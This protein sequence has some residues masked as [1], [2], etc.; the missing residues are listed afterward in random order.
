MSN[1]EATGFRLLQTFPPSCSPAD[2]RLRSQ[3]EAL[4]RISPVAQEALFSGHGQSQGLAALAARQPRNAAGRNPP[5]TRAG[6]GGGG[7]ASSA[8]RSFL[9]PPRSEVEHS[10]AGHHQLCGK[11]C[12]STCLTCH[13]SAHKNSLSTSGRARPRVPVY[14]QGCV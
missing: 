12:V 1:L 6:G 13:G 5:T 7:L 8:A 9:S 2:L 11:P 14:I 10:H 4:G 3:R